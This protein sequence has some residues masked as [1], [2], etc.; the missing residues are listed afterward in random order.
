[1]NFNNTLLVGFYISFIIIFT[2]CYWGYTIYR[3]SKTRVGMIASSKYYA[4]MTETDPTKMGY[5]PKVA[6][7][8]VNEGS[9]IVRFNIYND[10]IPSV[11]VDG[12]IRRYNIVDSHE[13]CL[14][15]KSKLTLINPP[16]F[17]ECSLSPVPDDMLKKCFSSTT[18]GLGCVWL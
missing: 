12:A 10:G 8:S 15:T 4:E 6:S 2:Y 3:K 11:P 9:A 17:P 16:P 18:G 14:G 5:K 13:D 7:V 1:M